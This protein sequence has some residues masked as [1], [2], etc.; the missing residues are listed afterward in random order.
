MRD[1]FLITRGISSNMAS[2]LRPLFAS[3][4][5]KKTDIKIQL[6]IVVRSRQYSLFII[7]GEI[8]KEKHGLL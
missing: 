6:V 2:K 3:L 1:E 4:K 8:F 7:L 5:K